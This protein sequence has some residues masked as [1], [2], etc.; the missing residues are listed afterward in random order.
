MSS[1]NLQ[2][3]IIDGPMMAM[4]IYK[5]S[6]QKVR[7]RHFAILHIKSNLINKDHK[8]SLLCLRPTDLKTLTYAAMKTVYPCLLCLGLK[9]GKSTVVTENF[10]LCWSFFEEFY[11]DGK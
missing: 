11:T 6:S 3:I 10:T 7:G 5:K 1:A 8:R 4:T 2:E 9:S